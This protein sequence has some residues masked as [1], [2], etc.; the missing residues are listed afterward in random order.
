MEK[1]IVKKE[2]E[3]VAK[4]AYIKESTQGVED[5]EVQHILLPRCKVVQGLTKE[6]TE[7]NTPLGHFVNNITRVDYGEQI[8]F[9]CLF[10]K[11]G[12]QLYAEDE[13][14]KRGD[15]IAR[16]FA[17]DFLPSMNP[18]AITDD[19]KQWKGKTPPR[20]VETFLF[21]GIVN[22]EDLC[23][24]SLSS[25][26]ATTGKK[27]NTMLVS[28]NEAAFAKHYVFTTHKE[29]N[30]DGTFFVPDV[31]PNGY[32]S[33]KEYAMAEALFMKYSKAKLNPETLKEEPTPPGKK[34]DKEEQPF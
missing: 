31:K 34:K 33:E 12:W 25:K 21:V 5:I 14:G 6:H 19:M 29:T 1:D 13:K 24:I 22:G 28:R 32:L 27:L 17:G 20:A 9:I 26:A 7:D 11:P 10:A 23:A 2:T 18:E 3:A 15:L 4:P 16:K 8:D 30:D